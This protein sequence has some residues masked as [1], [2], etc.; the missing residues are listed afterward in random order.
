MEYRKFSRAIESWNQKLHMY[1]GLFLLLFIWLFSLSGLLL[2][3]S[4]WEFASFWEEREEKEGTYTVRIPVSADSATAITG[5]MEQL[6]A[7]GEVSNVNISTNSLNFRATKPG[8]IKDISVNLDTQNATVK[9]MNFNTW[10]IIR[11]L[12]TFN[13]TDSNTPQAN[14]IITHI[15]RFAMDIVA[16]G[17]IFLC[18]SSWYMWYKTGENLT[19]GLLI[20]CSGII[21]AGYF[22]LVLSQG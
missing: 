1:V 18:I 2:N 8:Q 4:K 7:E 10:G 11:T 20:L 22:V 9:E 21:S 5:V 12:H 16:I 15:W 3:N 17:L 6:K 14:W 19:L 13:G